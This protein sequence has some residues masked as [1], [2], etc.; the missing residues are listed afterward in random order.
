ME[1]L[2]GNFSA[3]PLH[4]PAAITVDISRRV[5]SMLST[6]S[7]C[8]RNMQRQLVRIPEKTNTCTL[9]SRLIETAHDIFGHIRESRSRPPRATD[10]NPLGGAQ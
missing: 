10:K 1:S 5:P 7:H 9:A 4:D 2:Y 3:I 6:W 8:N